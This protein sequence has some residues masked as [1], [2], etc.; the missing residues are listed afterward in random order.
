V[1]DPSILLTRNKTGYQFF[2]SQIRV[3]RAKDDPIIE[4][5]VDA[6]S[7]EVVEHIGSS[8][9]GG[10]QVAVMAGAT[11]ASSMGAILSGASACPRDLFPHRYGLCPVV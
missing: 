8:R 11:V 4:T 3:D 6:P 9:S 5:T 7:R 2:H 10:T 1:S